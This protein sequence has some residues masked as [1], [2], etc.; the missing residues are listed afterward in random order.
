MRRSGPRSRTTGIHFLAHYHLSFDLP[1][2]QAAYLEGLSRLFARNGIAFE[3]TAGGQINR[4]LPA[5]AAQ[6]IESAI[7]HTGDTECD[8]LLEY[9]RTTVTNPVL[10]QR[11]DRIEK[12]WNAFER[13]K[14]LEPG[15]DKRATAE[16][17][18]NRVVSGP[19]F[20]TLLCFE[21]RTITEAGNTLRIPHS[22]INQEIL[23]N[24]DEV[25]YLYIRMFG[26]VRLLLRASGRGG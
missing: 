15:P 13:M 21:Y 6:V 25:D 10:D 11:R 12:L 17:M 9:A 8:R 23:H 20:R 16:T 14:T 26:L 24:P 22:E 5:H 7:Y 3:M 1:A 18:L 2:G 4:L 19:V